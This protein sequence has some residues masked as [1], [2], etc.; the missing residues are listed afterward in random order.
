MTPFKATYSKSYRNRTFMHIGLMAVLAIVLGLTT[1]GNTSLLVQLAFIPIVVLM[2]MRVYGL[3]IVKTPFYV[4]GQG[5]RIM[6]F[7]SSL[8]KWVDIVGVSNDDGDVALDFMRNGTPAEIFLPMNMIQESPEEVL[9][10]IQ[11]WHD[12]KKGQ[13]K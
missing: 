3:F 12:H 4:D 11:N 7:G 9:A 1:G 5:V 8:V 13:F 10:A 2:G 6:S